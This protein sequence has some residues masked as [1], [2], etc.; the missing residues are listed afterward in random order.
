MPYLRKY[1]YFEE[2]WVWK[3]RFLNISNISTFRGKF[4]YFEITLKKSFYAH[5]YENIRRKGRFLETTLKKSIFFLYLQKFQHFKQIDFFYDRFYDHFVF[6]PY[7]RN[8]HISRKRTLLWKIF[9]PISTKISLLWSFWFFAN[10]YG[11]YREI[12][13]NIYISRKRTCF[14]RSLWKNKF[15]VISSKISTFRERLRIFWSLWK[16]CYLR[17]FPKYYISTEITFFEIT[18][19]KS[20]F[21]YFRNINITR[22]RT[23]F[24]NHFEKIF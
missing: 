12:S 6:C 21:S 7:L 10:R 15:V 5:N 1:Q 9:L 8:I 13:R 17:I 2:K 11:Q 18:L 3:N 19:K 24:W 16:W 4:R 14:F 22:K 20:F 23:L